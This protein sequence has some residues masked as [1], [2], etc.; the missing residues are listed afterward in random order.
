MDKEKNQT[1]PAE[2]GFTGDATQSDTM[3]G[4]MSK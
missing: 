3:M 2:D 1:P 4:E